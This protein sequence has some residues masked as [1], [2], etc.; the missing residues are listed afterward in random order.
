ML[1]LPYLLRIFNVGMNVF[2]VA[3]FVL[4]FTILFILIASLMTRK[5]KEETS[6]EFI[7]K[8][9]MRFLPQDIIKKGYPLYKRIGFW[10]VIMSLI[11]IFIQK[12]R[13]CR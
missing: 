2:N 6:E 8:S 1:I 12:T 11:Y 3:G 5:E 9:S 13:N 7:W 10:I 4:I